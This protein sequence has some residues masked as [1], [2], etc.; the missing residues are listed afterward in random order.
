MLT[1]RCL[2]D[3]GEKGIKQRNS[4]MKMPDYLFTVNI[5][6]KTAEFADRWEPFGQ[7]VEG[8]LLVPQRS[9]FREVCNYK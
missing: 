1:T 8:L 2:A 7:T 6:L 9:K 4:G 5:K 3:A